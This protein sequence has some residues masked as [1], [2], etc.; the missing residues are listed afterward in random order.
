MVLDTV[1]EEDGDWV[2]LSGVH[3][4][5]VRGLDAHV[6]SAASHRALQHEA[7]EIGAPRKL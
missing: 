1:G 3:Y 4:I 2:Q 5:T 7:M 6:A